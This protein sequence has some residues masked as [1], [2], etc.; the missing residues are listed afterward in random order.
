MRLDIICVATKFNCKV[1][2]RYVYVK[3]TK[4]V[5]EGLRGEEWR[6]GVERWRSGGGVEEEWSG[7]V[8]NI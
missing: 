1:M 4:E 5:A 2:R 7:E 3:W 8:E 6:S